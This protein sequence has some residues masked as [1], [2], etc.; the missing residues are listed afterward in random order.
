MAVDDEADA[1]EAIEERCG[2]AGGRE[3]CAGERDEDCGKKSLETS[4]V[5]R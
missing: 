1:K 2:R 3:G 5:Q 4:K